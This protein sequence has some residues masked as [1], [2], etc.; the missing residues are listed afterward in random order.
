[1]ALETTSMVTTA[2]KYAI[3]QIRCVSRLLGVCQALLTGC[4]RVANE[5]EDR[6]LQV[7]IALVVSLMNLLMNLLKEQVVCCMDKEVGARLVEHASTLQHFFQ[8]TYEF[9]SSDPDMVLDSNQGCSLPSLIDSLLQL[10][11]VLIS[12]QVTSQNYRTFVV[13][14]LLDILEVRSFKQQGPLSGQQLPLAFTPH[15][16]SHLLVLLQDAHARSNGEFE[17]QSRTPESSLKQSGSGRASSQLPVCEIHSKKVDLSEALH[18]QEQ[19]QIIF[20]S[21]GRWL[22]NLVAVTALMHA[23][24]LKEGSVMETASSVHSEEDSAVGSLDTVT[25]AS[26]DDALFGDLFSES[27]RHSINSEGLAPTSSSAK[28]LDALYNTPLQAANQA[29][30]FMKDCIFSPTWHRPTFDA[31]CKMLTKEHLDVFLQIY[32]SQPSL[33]NSNALGFDAGES[34]DIGS[35]VLAQLHKGSF[36]LLDTLVVKHVLSDSLE[37]HLVTQILK[38]G[39][40][41]LTA[42][43]CCLF[44]KLLINR[45]TRRGIQAPNDP[46]ALEFWKMFIDYVLTKSRNIKAV[47]LN[48][49]KALPSF[50]HME[51]LFMA[52]HSL[53][54][55]GRSAILRTVLGALK[56]LRNPERHHTILPGTPFAM[57]S[58]LV[59]RLVLALRYLLLHFDTYPRWLLV[60]LQ[61]KLQ[62]Q[63]F[64]T[65]LNGRGDNGPQQSWAGLVAHHIVEEHRIG[66]ERVLDELCIQQLL[67]IGG[68]LHVPGLQE[69]VLDMDEVSQVISD[70]LNIWKGRSF[71]M[72]E[73]LVF[74]RYIYVMGWN[75]VCSISPL[76]KQVAPWE[77]TGDS[78]TSLG[79]DFVLGISKCLHTGLSDGSADQWVGFMMHNLSAVQTSLCKGGVK[80]LAWDLLRQ[81][82]SLTML[83]SM[84]QAMLWSLYR[85]GTASAEDSS[86]EEKSLKNPKLQSFLMNT[87]SILLKDSYSGQLLQYLSGIL[88]WY[89][90]VVRDAVSHALREQQPCKATSSSI[91]LLL[92]GGLT[93]SKQLDLLEAIGVSASTLQSLLR[94]ATVSAWPSQPLIFLVGPECEKDKFRDLDSILI[95]SLLHGFPLCSRPGSAAVLSAMMSIE[96]IIDT[97]QILF[98]TQ[99]KEAGLDPQTLQK[100]MLDGLLG[101]IMNMKL[102]STFECVHSKCTAVLEMLLPIKEEQALYSDMCELKHAERLLQLLCL[103]RA[104]VDEAVWEAVVLQVLEVYSTIRSDS[105]RFEAL[106][107]YFANQQ[108]GGEEINVEISEKCRNLVGS[109]R[110]SLLIDVLDGCPSEAVNIKALQLIVMLL[111]YNLRCKNDLQQKFLQMDTATLSDWLEQ[112]FL[113]WSE[114]V[115]ESKLGRRAASPGVR[116]LAS[117]LVQSL[118]LSPAE[119]QGRKLH[120]HLLSSMLVNL[121][122]AFVAFDVLAA[123]SYF[124]LMVQL[125][126][127]E[128]LLKRLLETVV[129]LVGKL[130]VNGSH[131]EG[132]KTIISFL[133]S[134][135]T[136]CGGNKVQTQSEQGES[137]ESHINHSGLLGMKA[138]Q[139][140]FRKSSELLLHSTLESGVEDCDAMSVDEDEDDATSDG[141]IASLDRDDEDD[142]S[143]SERSLASRVCTFTSSGSN[144]L[145]QHWYFCYTCD[146][147]V[148]KGCCSVCAKVCHK[149]HK[150]VYSRLSRFFCD[151]GA[152]GVRGTSCLCLKPRKYVSPTSAVLPTESNSVENFLPLNSHRGDLPPSDSDTDDEEEDHCDSDEAFKISGLEGVEKHLLGVLS[153]LDVEGQVLSLCKKLLSD[154]NLGHRLTSRKVEEVEVSKDRTL[155]FKSDLL[156]L[157][158]AY[159]SGSLDMKI[160]AEY[161]N[162]RELKSHLVSGL[163]VKSLLTIS[164]RGRLAAG[165]G[166]KVTIFDVGQLIGQPTAT[167]VTVDKTTVKP[168]SKN[169][170]RFE[171]VQ[172]AFNSAN[173]SYLAVAGYEDCQVFTV[174]PRG[175]VTDRLAV[176]LALQDAYIRRVAWVP[177]SQVEL[178]VVTNKFVKI[179]D[180]SQDKISPS[181]YFTILEDSIA[182]AALVSAG[183]GQLTALVL[184]L[185]GVLYSQCVTGNDTGAR[186]LT[187]NIQLPGDYKPVKGVSMHYSAAYKLLFLSYSDNLTLMARLNSDLTGFSQVAHVVEEQDEKSRA[188]GLHHWKE[189]FEG[190]GLF[191]CLS[192]QR[193]NTAVAVQI[194]TTE[195]HS[196]PL[197]MTGSPS[198]LR[199]DGVAAY[200]PMTKERNSVLVLHDDGSL[201]VFSFTSLL[202]EANSSLNAGD[203]QKQSGTLEAEQVKKLGAVLLGSQAN[204][205]GSSP[206]FPLDF[207]ESTTCITADVKLG[208][209]ILRNN[210]SEGVKLSLAAEDGFLEGPSSS[211]FKVMFELQ[212]SL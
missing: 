67:D 52:F 179:Y 196:Q 65:N 156:Q 50:F 132:L 23:Q 63:S 5:E 111:G 73:E 117:S 25:V 151:C 84:L 105:S 41:S 104:E 48:M 139:T 44:A 176:E 201:Q 2:Q 24:G 22:D 34:E 83:L 11:E 36:D 159:K 21:D 107:L 56:S 122:R 75:M 112:R 123:K 17:Q 183:Q 193:S 182:D 170:V 158:R 160:K 59:S 60:N 206:V 205:G 92:Q 6:L 66:E 154:L 70:V 55:S 138:K 162:A 131:V 62:H 142:G 98:D 39:D 86:S 129:E 116:D 150:V 13:A 46:L 175:E 190:S 79:S 49:T 9:S 8:H 101:T 102:D 91:D 204:N 4:G 192:S 181:H 72:V 127:G 168:L 135:L 95:P 202:P 10:S 89:V 81:G 82:S 12:D 47:D 15:V 164:S 94:W 165:E 128:S 109:G 31:A 200:R 174:N 198:S 141:E 133:N 32:F 76:L 77:M 88:A 68:S 16:L 43:S 171:V 152:G 30:S 26:E 42:K 29:M 153:D 161:P 210:D 189:M 97:V 180:L 113:G 119:D 51:V 64:K 45:S 184:S 110:V 157:K 80:L 191:V 74:E 149:G 185:Q 125:A 71:K 146:L 130:H 96:G 163:L 121:E 178:M 14:S 38:E 85:R 169:A 106:Q 53:D 27:G 69:S 194:G 18:P 78:I 136:A 93:K 37:L 3:G 172:L 35:D 115:S 144:F 114:E 1:V 155:N 33:V 19:L 143:S 208:G 99:G 137:R 199:V 134:I 188:A 186:I 100:G 108:Q 211:G 118:V 187:E 195:T 87:S 57:W 209:D 207:F 148:S 203:N 61:R 120:T 40:A 7:R 54:I 126:Q 103:K 212:V 147:T 145:E 173:E 58:L 167:P 90:E 20:P 177:G 124:G 28:K 197:R 140:P 166:D